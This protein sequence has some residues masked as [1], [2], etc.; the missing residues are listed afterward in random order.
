MEQKEFIQQ[1]KITGEDF[2][3]RFKEKSEELAESGKSVFDTELNNLSEALHSAADKLHQ[4]ED[5]MAQF[6]DKAVEKFD[7]LAGYI[8]EHNA[9]EL[10]KDVNEVSKRSPYI[11]IGGMFVA[12]LALSRF[13]KS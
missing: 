4:K 1:E 12:G 10:V 9:S 3:N 7:S 13:L 8:K 2:S 6:G 5:F 11:A